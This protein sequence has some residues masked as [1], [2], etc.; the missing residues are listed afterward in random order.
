MGFF[1][2]L[3][4]FRFMTLSMTNKAVNLH[5]QGLQYDQHVV[6]VAVLRRRRESRRRIQKESPGSGATKNWEK[7]FIGLYK[8]NL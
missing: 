5:L 7:I 6:A 3:P 8:K 4:S 1:E 2:H